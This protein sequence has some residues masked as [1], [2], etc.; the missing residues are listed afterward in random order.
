VIGSF[1][2][3]DESL[4]GRR[5]AWRVRQRAMAI[6]AVFRHGQEKP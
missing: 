4:I 6:L 5:D 2:A 3:A 1:D